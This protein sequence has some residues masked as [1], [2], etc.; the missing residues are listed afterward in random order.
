MREWWGFVVKWV[1]VL[2]LLVIGDESG[3]VV[4]VVDVED[5]DEVV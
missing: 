5:R 2:V 4:P 1:V 3:E